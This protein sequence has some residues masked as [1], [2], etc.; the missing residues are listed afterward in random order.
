MSILIRQK[1]V[2]LM[3]KLK[4]KLK[5]EKAPKG[6]VVI[7]VGEARKRYVVPIECLS[8]TMFQALINQFEETLLPTH[9]GPITLPCSPEMFEWVL[10]L[11]MADSTYLSRRR[12]INITDYVCVC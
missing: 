11:V 8:S 2:F 1:L 9:D 3:S 6:F 5:R 4:L 10:D 12:T 7:Y